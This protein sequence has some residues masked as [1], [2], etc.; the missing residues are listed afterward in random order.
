M[1]K[2]IQR[3]ASMFFKLIKPGCA[4]LG[5]TFNKW[6]LLQTQSSFQGSARPGLI[7]IQQPNMMGVKLWALRHKLH[8]FLYIFHC[9]HIEVS[10][11]SSSLCVDFEVVLA[12]ANLPLMRMNQ[13]QEI[14]LLLFWPSHVSR[15][16][17]G[18]CLCHAPLLWRLQWWNLQ[19]LGLFL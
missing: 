10:N 5:M 3:L 1:R 13:L 8:N 11:K 17:F 7:Q 12:S 14:N 18:S 9:M 6:S 19:S 4:C 15:Y 16:Y 2:Q